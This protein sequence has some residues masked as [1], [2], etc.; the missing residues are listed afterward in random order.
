VS[1]CIQKLFLNNVPVNHIFCDTLQEIEI[2][3]TLDPRLVNECE[4]E[5][6]RSFCSA[7][8]YAGDRLWATI[9]IQ[10]HEAGMGGEH[11]DLLTEVGRA[12]GIS[13]QLVQMREQLPATKKEG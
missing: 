6:F 2:Y 9:T 7:P 10:A 11:A 3:R 12:L 8:V 4:Q 13:I 1:N 5:G